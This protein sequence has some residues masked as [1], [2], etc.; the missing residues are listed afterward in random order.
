MNKKSLAL[1]ITV[2]ICCI[3]IAAVETVIEPAYAVKSAVKAAMFLAAPLAVMKIF[4]IKAFGESFKLSLKSF[5][6]LLA[7]GGGIYLIVI[8]GYLIT[9]NLFDYAELVASLSKDQKVS[10]ERFIPVAVYISIGN[11]FLEEFLFRQVAFLKLKE[12]SS[13]KTA[14]I[15]SSLMFAVYHVAMIGQSFPPL[16]LIP[17]LVGLAVGGLIFDWVDEKGGHIYGSW[18]IHAFADFAL[19]TVWLIYI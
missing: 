1:I 8:A 14:Y 5:M 6:K 12:L 13:A 10:A 15:F 11:S 17:S 19:M 4:G 7:L 16:L 9:K 2:V 18:F 3:V